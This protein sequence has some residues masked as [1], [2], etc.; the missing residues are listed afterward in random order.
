[1]A[2]DIDP[3]LKSWEFNP[4]S[5]Q[6]RVVKVS[7]EREVLQI[8]LDLG[9]MQM[10]MTGRPDGRKPEGFPTYF[11]YLKHLVTQ[12]NKEGREFELN[13]THCREADR[14][15]VQFYHRRICYLAL[16]NYEGAIADANH[17]LEFMDL[18]RDHAP[19]EEVKEAHERYRPFVLFHKT[20]ALAALH[21]EG[22]NPEKGIDHIRNGLEILHKFFEDQNLLEQEERDPF[23]KQLRAMDQQLRAKFNIEATLSEQLQAAIQRE[24]YEAAAR[25]RDELR[26]RQMHVRTD[27]G[28]VS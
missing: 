18:V 20:Q 3:I 4:D 27:D 6:T 26:N 12:A 1:M 11:D 9:I 24:D 25:L 10:E 8:R 2:D 15:F 21:S 7:P 17:T 14:E 19:N 16:S 23:V 28:V 22:G 5:L 13:E